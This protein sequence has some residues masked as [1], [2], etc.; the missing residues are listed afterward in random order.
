VEFVE[1]LKEQLEKIAPTR[2]VKDNERSRT[3]W[4]VEG[5]FDLVDGGDP[6]ARYFLGTF[7]A[8]ESFLALHVRI[9]DID[10]GLVVYEF[11]MAGGS[12]GRGRHGTV[13][14][15]G[16]GRATHFDLSNAAERIYLTLSANPFRYGQPHQVLA[17]PNKSAS[18]RLPSETAVFN[19]VC[20]SLIWELQGRRV[21]LQ[22]ACD[23]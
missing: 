2:I 15:S 6:Y 9:T 20:R 10:R 7:G 13:R 19:C 17:C 21:P 1:D 22:S 23:F 8:G 14:A 18:V 11:D 16:L 3:G 4:L 12:R 5:Q